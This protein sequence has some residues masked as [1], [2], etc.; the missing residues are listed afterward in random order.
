MKVTEAGLG[1][2]SGCTVTR[3]RPGRPGRTGNLKSECNSGTIG[4]GKCCPTI[5]GSSCRPAEV[6]AGRGGIPPGP[7][8]RA[9]THHARTIPSA[10]IAARVN[11]HPIQKTRNG[12]HIGT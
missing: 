1:G 7:G 5:P 9:R 12:K 4:E 10:A 3:R 2:I 11:Q 8:R 6:T